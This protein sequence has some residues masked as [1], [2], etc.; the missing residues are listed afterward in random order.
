M[1]PVSVQVNLCG[2]VDGFW[3]TLEHVQH[4]L[5]ENKTTGD[6]DASQE[7]STGTERLRNSGREVSAAHDENS[8]NT[9][10]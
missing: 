5:C 7:H 6:V 8:G 2:D 10:L 9:D 1:G 4:A 3:L